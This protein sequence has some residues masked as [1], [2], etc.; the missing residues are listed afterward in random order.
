MKK[1][2]VIVIVA[3]ICGTALL[4]FAASTAEETWVVVQAG[5]K[6]IAAFVS[7]VKPYTEGGPA[8]SVYLEK[9]NVRTKEGLVVTGFE[10]IGWKEA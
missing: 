7:G 4:H 10:F 1:L 5:G 2:T 6:E 9:R 3:V 8:V